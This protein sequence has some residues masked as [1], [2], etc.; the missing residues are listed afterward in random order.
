MIKI[1]NSL[2]I[3][4]A[5]ILAIIIAQLLK[6]DF[7]ISAGIVAILS[8][9]PTKKE[10]LNTA[11]A[12]FYAFLI[13][14][15][16]AGVCYNTIGFNAYAFFAYLLIFIPFCQFFGFYSA[17]AMDSVLISH[18]ITLKSFTHTE[19]IN[20]LGLFL[21][22]V[23]FGILANIFLHKKT[24]KIES[25][26][27]EADEQIRQILYK[28]SQKILN[29]DFA[30]YN[31]D[32]FKKLDQAILE[33]KIFAR[34]NSNNQFRKADD[35]DEKYIEMREKQREILQEIY[36]C[37]IELKT[38]PSTA[39]RVSDFFQ[40][41]SLEYEKNNDVL[42]LIDELQKIQTEMKEIKLPQNRDEFEDRAILFVML[43]RMN[44]FL[45]VK[46]DFYVTYMKSE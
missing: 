17:M 25:L 30:S 7:A 6:M 42:D 29:L 1:I 22:G 16:I 33:A 21:I 9:Q 10:T 14:L 24:D 28:M 5:A 3:I 26:K 18:F 41:V 11:L 8:V 37:I 13:A 4:T 2:K 23:S 44:D 12:R 35:F 19:I 36:Q 27:N 43:K 31:G 32:C 45:K 40:K 39:K 46:R 15:F 20:E 34:E 38:V